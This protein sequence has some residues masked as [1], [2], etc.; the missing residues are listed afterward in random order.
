MRTTILEVLTI[1]NLVIW[2]VV[3]PYQ[4]AMALVG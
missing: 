1:V 3:V 2:A 4:I